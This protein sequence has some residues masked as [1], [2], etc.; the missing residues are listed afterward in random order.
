MT[1]SRFCNL[2]FLGYLAAMGWSIDSTGK[3]VLAVLLTVPVTFI[4]WAIVSACEDRKK[5][6]TMSEDWEGRP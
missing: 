4:L 2:V 3:A 5:R 6:I 1:A